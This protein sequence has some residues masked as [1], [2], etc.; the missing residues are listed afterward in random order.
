M[1]FIEIDYWDTIKKADQLEELAR[2]LRNIAAGDLSRIQSGVSRNWQGSAA[3]LYQKRT[4][5]FSSQVEG[6]ARQLQALA[7]ELRQAAER[8]RR[9]EQLASGLF[10]GAVL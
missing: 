4:R 10:G 7:R 1:A 2:D 5:T 6:Q 9:L 3:Q 8:Y